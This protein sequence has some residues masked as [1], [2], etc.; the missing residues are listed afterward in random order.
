MIL[1]TKV[2]APHP[3]LNR[4]PNPFCVQI[5]GAAVLELNGLRDLISAPASC[6]DFKVANLFGEDRYGWLSLARDRRVTCNVGPRFR[7]GFLS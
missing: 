4:Y 6:G 2:F 5:K 1:R 3:E 7:I